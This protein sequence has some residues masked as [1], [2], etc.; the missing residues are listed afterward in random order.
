MSTNDIRDELK[1]M[2]SMLA[3]M[4]RSMS[5][6]IPEHYFTDVEG[7][8]KLVLD[9]AGEETEARNWGK[10]MPYDVPKDYFEALA[11]QVVNAVVIAEQNDIPVGYFDAL[12][13]RMLQAAKVEDVKPRLIPLFTQLRWAAA[14][15]LLICIS[16]GGYMAFD[17][18]HPGAENILAAVPQTEIQEYLQNTERPDEGRL[19][20]NTAINSLPVDNA[21]IISYLDETGWE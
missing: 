19:V 8:V 3:D 16:I 14:A 10:E 7:K 20:D 12:P 15:V 6:V 18:R 4:P 1:G 2:G 9:I 17:N 5:Y 11:G 21:E 13:G